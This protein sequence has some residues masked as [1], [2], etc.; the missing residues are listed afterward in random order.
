VRSRSRP[1]RATG[2][3]RFLRHPT[4]LFPSTGSKK[5]AKVYHGQAVIYQGGIAA[6]PSASFPSTKHPPHRG[7]PVFPVCGKH[8]P[9]ML[10][11]AATRPTSSHRQLRSPLRPLP[12]LAVAAFRLTLPCSSVCSP[13]GSLTQNCQ[14]L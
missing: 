10:A 5:P 8:L 9:G 3:L 11:E 7:G 12:R 2:P 14:L 1:E 6:P 13:D 4:R